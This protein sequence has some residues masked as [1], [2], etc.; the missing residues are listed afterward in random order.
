MGEVPAGARLS[1][2]AAPRRSSPGGPLAWRYRPEPLQLAEAARLLASCE[3]LVER[4]GVLD[5]SLAKAERVCCVESVAS[6]S[7]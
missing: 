6:T 4:Q 2:S 7:S 5:G 3:S 1:G